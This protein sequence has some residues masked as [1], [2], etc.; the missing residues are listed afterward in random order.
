MQKRIIILGGPTASGK[1]ALALDLAKK[2]DTVIINADSQQV[3]REIPII[4]AQPSL[5]EQTQVPHKLYGIISVQELFS[6]ALWLEL[7]AKQ[8]NDV[9]AQGKTP[10]LVGGTGMYIKSLVE[11][12]A[13]VPEISFD[14][15]QQVR[16][17]CDEHG[18]EAIHAILMEK[19]PQIATKLKPGDRQRVL[20]A[21]E[22]LLETGKSLLYW[23]QQKTTPIFPTEMFKTFFLLPDRAEV[24]KKCDLRLIQML[25]NGLL[26]EVRALDKMQ[27]PAIFPAMRAHG[28]R[29][30]IAHLHGEI[31][32]SDATA[33]AQQATRNYVKRQFTWFRH[34]MQDAVAITGADDIVI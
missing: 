23:Q 8:I 15:R 16:Q 17:M 27:V 31:S 30:F 20:R 13:E 33:A 10:L 28:L 6:V 22:V 19:D 34:Q 29:E 21:Y 12:I 3:Y 1:S 5:Y 7:V 11:G 4:T 18:P 26:D 32:L 9:L 24:Y 2:I 14:I 25:E